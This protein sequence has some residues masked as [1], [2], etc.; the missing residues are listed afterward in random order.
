MATL[1]IQI[2]DSK[3]IS[4]NGVNVEKF[5]D[6]YV[7]GNG[8]KCQIFL[9]GKIFCIASHYYKGNERLIKFIIQSG[10]VKLKVK[11]GDNQ[12]SLMKNYRLNQW[13]TDGV[14]R[15]SNNF[16]HPRCAY[17]REASFQRFLD[18]H[19]ITSVRYESANGIY[20]V[21]QENDGENIIFKEEIET[22]GNVE[23]IYN[24][25]KPRKEGNYFIVERDIE[26]S[27]ATWVVKIVRKLGVVKHRILYTTDN[28][29]KIIGLPKFE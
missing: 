21:L 27:N 1:Q 24:A 15:L 8:W 28:P 4:H 29:E 10:Y 3:F 6:K 18:E 9:N 11:V 20:R 23:L 13:S 12:E 26:V 14:L 16:T 5:T 17:F 19:G 2:K 25:V 22:D 7:E